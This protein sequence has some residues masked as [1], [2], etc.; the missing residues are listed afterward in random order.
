VNL[1]RVENDH[2]LFHLAKQERELLALIL[3]LYPVIPAAHQPLSKSAANPNPANQRLLDEAL[4]EQ[5][6][7]NKKLV[8]SFLADPQRFLETET[9]C[10]LTLTAAEIE[11]LLQVLND[12]HVGSWIRLGSPDKKLTRVAPD[13]PNAP[14]ALA[15]DLATFFQMH[16]LEAVNEKQ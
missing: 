13:D 3:R 16:L 14:H 7:E 4:A 2:Y 12:V 6:K 1:L 11:W 10:R 15:M 5:R 8:Q 9:S